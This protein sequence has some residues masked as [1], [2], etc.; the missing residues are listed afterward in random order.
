M[1]AMSSDTGTPAQR[2][3]SVQFRPERTNIL[4]ALLMI[5]IAALVVGSA[6][7]YLFWVFLIPLVFIYWIIRARTVVGE[8]GIEVIYAF[9]PGRS[10][11]WDDLAGVGFK[12]ARALATTNDGKQYVMP[13]VSFNSL[14]KLAEASR[15]RIP[16]VLTAGRKA[17][18]EQVVIINRDGEEIMLTKEEY[19]ARK[20]QTNDDNNNSPRSNQ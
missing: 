17:A 9:R 3:A 15:G 2:P 5:A 11:A 20:R 1:V 19:A 13:G 8:K 14:P 16:D 18:D 10:I 6:P 7:L 4:A 12:G